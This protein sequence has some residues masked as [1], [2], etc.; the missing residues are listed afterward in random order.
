MRVLHIITTISRGGSENHLVELVRLQVRSGLE[1]HVAYL[2]GDGYWKQA[3]DEIGV[4]ITNLKL[5]R[6][7]NLAPVFKLRRL[8][9]GINPEIIHAHMPPAELYA[10]IALLL[11]GTGSPRFLISKHNDEPFYP[12]LGAATIG[13]FVANRAYRLIAIS[14]AVNR[15]TQRNLGIKADR[16][17]TVHYGIDP[18]PYANINQDVANDLRRLWDIPQDAFVIGAVARLVPQK[19]LHV[20]LRAFAQYRE[21]SG[22]D[23]RLVIV[24]QGP[25]ESELK[26]LSEQLCLSRQVV[27]AGFRDDIPNV[28]HAFDCF[29]LTSQYE[30]FGL[31][32]L[33]AM[34]AR[35]PVAV[36]SVSAIPEVVQDG[37]TGILCA[38]DSPDSVA[39]A[40]LRLENVEYRK[41]L[42]RAG[43]LR[44][45][46]SF[47]LEKM[48]SKTL[49]IYQECL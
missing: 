5:G 46:D 28:M 12:G 27:W 41:D 25:L 34:A 17:V 40:F 31:V 8:I 20:M 32:L 29:A 10:R 44:V 2:K 38:I 23:S 9:A 42:G 11:P 49:A 30:G 37:V 22:L 24:G 7:G 4:T 21:K 1:V 3:F 36:T 33:E 47:S 18:Q 43:L 39:E 19:A 48:I 6:Y 26:L 15:Y 35:R 13:R 14:D 45:T 16:I